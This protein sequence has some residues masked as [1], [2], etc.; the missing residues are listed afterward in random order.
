M[1]QFVNM[2]EA[3]LS[4]TFFLFTVSLLHIADCGLFREKNVH[5]LHDKDYSSSFVQHMHVCLTQWLIFTFHGDT[6]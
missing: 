6:T 1:M 5:Q 3:P 4:E 2:F